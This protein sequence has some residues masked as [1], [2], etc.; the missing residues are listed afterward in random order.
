MTLQQRT[1][2]QLA[3]VKRTLAEKYTRKALASGSRPAQAKLLR[4]AEK[5][6]Q[7]AQNIENAMA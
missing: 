3:Q 6:R 1:A 7:Q 2:R 5:Y 4:Q